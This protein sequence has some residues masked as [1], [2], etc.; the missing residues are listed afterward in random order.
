M[1]RCLHFPQC[2]H[3]NRIILR[4]N[5]DYFLK[6]QQ[7]AGPHNGAQFNL[8]EAE[9]E[10]SYELYASRLNIWVSVIIRNLLLLSRILA[11]SADIFLLM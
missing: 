10:F 8:C 11:L 6:Q 4:I 3:G 5:S 9:T 7:L 1:L 2:I